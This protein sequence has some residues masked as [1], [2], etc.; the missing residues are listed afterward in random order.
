MSVF[1]SMSGVQ[2]GA[3]SWGVIKPSMGGCERGI[4][5]SIRGVSDLY[6][7]TTTED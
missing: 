7:K 6:R 2:G 4:R 5:S 1:M 3:N